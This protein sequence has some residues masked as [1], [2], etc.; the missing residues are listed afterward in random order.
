[1]SWL[2]A[3]CTDLYTRPLASAHV[4]EVLQPPAPRLPVVPLGPIQFELNAPQKRQRVRTEASRPVALEALFSLTPARSALPG[5]KGSDSCIP[6][7]SDPSRTNS[8]LPQLHDDDPTGR[9][10]EPILRDGAIY[11][12]IGG[13]TL[14]QRNEESVPK[15]CTSYQSHV[16]SSADV[17]GTVVQDIHERSQVG[18]PTD[19]CWSVVDASHEAQVE[20]DNKISKKRGALALPQTQ[21]QNVSAVL[22]CSPGMHQWNVIHETTEPC[23]PHQVEAQAAVP[24]F[25]STAELKCVP[26]LDSSIGQVDHVR[27]TP[28]TPEVREHHKADSFPALSSR[29]KEKDAAS[30]LPMPPS[31]AALSQNPAQAQ[32]V[33]TSSDLR[34]HRRQETPCDLLGSPHKRH[35]GHSS[36]VCHKGTAAMGEHANNHVSGNSS[37]KLPDRKCCDRQ[38]CTNKYTSGGSKLGVWNGKMRCC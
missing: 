21:D 25:P 11:G 12:A 30:S 33:R 23:D 5:L 2:A 3:C 1:M 38:Q 10:T 9:V 6:S 22:Q 19:A 32:P 18:L 34:R 36:Q 27:P 7:V 15:V 13:A 16:I 17:L 20:I 28:D 37:T 26:V 35:C 4:E 24:G 31:T 8:V 14:L 29:C